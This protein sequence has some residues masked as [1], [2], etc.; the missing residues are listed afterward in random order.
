ML[1]VSNHMKLFAGIV[2]LSNVVSLLATVVLEH[3]IPPVI[4]SVPVA[5][6]SEAYLIVKSTVDPPVPNNTEDILD[7]IY[8]TSVYRIVRSSDAV[9]YD[10]VKDFGPAAPVLPLG[11]E[12]SNFASLVFPEFVTVANEPGARVIV[13]LAIIENRVGS[14]SV[15]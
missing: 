13:L 14:I 7:T 9:G 12:K 8:S 3:V 2:A 1:D 4:T 11:I 15:P 5:E 6:R 10:I